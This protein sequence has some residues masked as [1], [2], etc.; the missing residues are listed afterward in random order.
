MH[1]VFYILTHNN[2]L[3]TDMK[4][5]FP[6]KL[7]PT[8]KTLFTMNSRRPGPPHWMAVNGDGW[9][10]SNPCSNYW[11]LTDTRSSP[12][13]ALRRLNSGETRSYLLWAAQEGL[14]FSAAV[15]W[16]AIDWYTIESTVYMIAAHI[17]T[18]LFGCLDVC[19]LHASQNDAMTP[20]SYHFRHHSPR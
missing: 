8:D 6:C 3:K 19:C 18:S 14:F 7:S 2:L 9:C 1:S 17:D 10:V 11:P 5:T 20:L 4:S 12:L 16:P 15:T 13:S